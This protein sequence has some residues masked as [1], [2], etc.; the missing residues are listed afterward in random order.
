M[1][2]TLWCV[3]QVVFVLLWG[4]QGDGA[5]AQSPAKKPVRIVVGFAA[6]GAADVSARI[7]APE[8]SRL[9]GQSVIVENRAGANGILAA[10]FVAGAPPD[11]TILHVPANGTFTINPSLYK[12]LRYDPLKDFSL[13]S[14]IVVMANVLI[15]HPSLP[16]KSVRELV[17]LAKARPGQLMYGSGGVGGIP[18]LSGALFQTMT[19]T[20]LV[21]VPYQSGGQSS[22]AVLSGEVAMTFNTLI[23]SIP[24][25]KTGRFRAL[26]VTTLKRVPQLPE[27]PTISESGVLG[28]ESSTWYG[29]AG[30]PGLPAEMVSALNAGLSKVLVMNNV[31]RAFDEL[32]AVPALETPDQFA[33]TIRKDLAKWAKVVKEAN[34][35]SH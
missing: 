4:C 15:V 28:Y 5:L 14:R 23:T 16:A 25:I 18:H 20:D 22:I 32:G 13:V 6:G 1:R 31:V 26:A 17:K 11:G 30:P 10:E 35:A 19:G 33:E 21:H 12:K 2:R 29:L 8:M 9:L 24:H 3:I 27:T 7:I 34:I